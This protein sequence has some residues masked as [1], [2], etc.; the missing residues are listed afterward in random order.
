MN[1]SNMGAL[2]LVAGGPQRP[3]AALRATDSHF[4][5]VRFPNPQILDRRQRVW[6][7]PKP[8][9]TFEEPQ[10]SS[11]VSSF[12]ANPYRLWMTGPESQ[13]LQAIQGQYPKSGNRLLQPALG[14][15]RG[16]ANRVEVFVFAAR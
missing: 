9:T 2:V 16:R 15:R 7:T 1:D 3:P 10:A 14:P 11:V 12:G 8:K 13:I 5:L 4:R 6:S